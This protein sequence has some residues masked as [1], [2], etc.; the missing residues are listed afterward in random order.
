MFITLR[1]LSRFFLYTL[2][3][4]RQISKALSCLTTKP[5]SRKNLASLTGQL[6][7]KVLLMSN[8]CYLVNTFLVFVDLELKPRCGQRP[9][10]FHLM[11]SLYFCEVL[12]VLAVFK[13]RNQ[14]PFI[15]GW[16]F[17]SDDWNLDSAG[18]PTGQFLQNVF[19]FFLRKLTI[20]F[21]NGLP[22]SPISTVLK[23][24]GWCLKVRAEQGNQLL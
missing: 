17:W 3:H 16:Y 2:C 5:F 22:K 21:L 7:L 24:H 20:S 6:C 23:I 18:D 8:A 15:S 4:C 1:T 12:V 19:F 10:S 14:F 9:S 13:H 11:T